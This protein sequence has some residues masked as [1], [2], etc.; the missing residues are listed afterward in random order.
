VQD[1]IIMFL[2]L[3]MLTASWGTSLN[4]WIIC[5][6]WCLFFYGFGVGGEYPMTATAAMENSTAAGRVSARE[7]RLHRGRKV[8]L[9][10]LMQGWGQFVNQ[11][12]LV[13][14]LLIFNSGNGDGPYEARIAQYVFRISF[15]IAAVG[16]LWLVYHRAYQMP[17]ASHQ[18]KVAKKATNVTGYD[19]KSLRLTFTHFGSRL[20]ATSGTWFCNDFFFYGNKLFQSEFISVI[21]HGSTS[22]M[23]GWEWNLANIAVSLAGY[24]LACEYCSITSMDV[25]LTIRSVIDR[26]QVL[27]SKIYDASRLPHGFYLLH[28][29]RILL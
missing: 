18:L 12:V 5:Y 21:S 28:Y 22:I 9:A 27:W 15:A 26:Q 25:K 17:L 8:I 20:L 24:H 19:T 14:L 23:E 2:G 7:D 13:L 16:T 3:L 29:S 1:A 4:G 11:I 10:F 6:A